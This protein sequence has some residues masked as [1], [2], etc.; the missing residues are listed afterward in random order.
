LDE[1]HG[2]RD[3]WSGYPS[4]PTSGGTNNSNVPA[5]LENFFKFPYPRSGRY[6]D[7][8]TKYLASDKPAYVFHLH[9]P[10]PVTVTS[11]FLFP[12]AGIKW[13]DNKNEKVFWELKIQPEGEQDFFSNPQTA[14]LNVNIPD[15]D[16]KVAAY[17]NDPDL[18]K[19]QVDQA[20]P[21]RRVV[22]LNKLYDFTKPGHYQIQVSHTDLYLD[23]SGSSLGTFALDVTVAP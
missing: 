19:A 15:R 18:I 22:D 2:G 23:H 20:H 11:V 9:Q 14:E 10:M 6:P 21:Y 5:T 4:R 7:L 1:W 13:L 16:A 3:L 12:D 17:L 8:P